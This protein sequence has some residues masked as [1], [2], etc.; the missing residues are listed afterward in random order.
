MI[1]T[2]TALA[3]HE[4][5]RIAI[6]GD[7]LL[8]RDLA[9]RSAGF[10]VDGLA[11]FGAG[12]ESA[13]LS[14]VAR[15]P[16]LREAMTWQNPAAVVNALDRVAEG[17]GVS[18]SKSRRREDVVASYWQ[19]YCAKN[20]TIGFY[21]PL[22][23]GRIAD[24]PAP[25]LHARSGDLIRERSVHLESWGVQTLA[26]SLDPELRVALGPRS[27]DDLRRL[28]EDHPDPG[29][30]ARGL[31]A[32][33]A[34]EAARDAL[35]RADGAQLPAALA[36]LDAEF[37]RLTGVAPT[38]H[39]GR[40]YGARTL[41]YVDCMRD[42]DVTLGPGFVDDIAPV[43]RAVFEAGRWYCGRI[44]AIGEAVIAAA[45]P[46][47]GRMPFAAIVPRIL[48]PL[49]ALPPAIDA[50]LAE[51]QRRVAALLDDPDETTLAAR[52]A[53]AF[54]DHQDAWRFA[55]YQSVDVQIAARDERAVRDGDYLAVIGD[56][57]PGSNP[58][59][60]GLFGNR[61]PSPDV[62]FELW[63]HEAGP[64]HLFLL[65]PWGPGI[66]A[67]ARGVPLLGDDAIHI[68]INPESCAPNGRR[69][70]RAEELW[71]EG[72]D[73]VDASGALRIA[74]TDVFAVPVFVTAVRTFELWPPAAHAS[75]LTVGRV[76][77]RRESWDVAPSEIPDS[78][79]DF[80]AWA[81]ALG[82]P[83]RVFVK[84]PIERKPFYL[85]L[86]SPA[87]RRIALRHMRAARGVGEPIRF[88]E[89]LPD[90]GQCWLADADGHRYASELRLV[91]VA[92]TPTRTTRPTV[93]REAC[94][95]NE[96]QR[97]VS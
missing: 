64:E 49:M 47:E 48:G 28:L 68:A 18:T 90:P 84:T 24:A 15:D 42:L 43:L 10:P 73:V 75:R 57:H 4:A 50:E 52:A 35:A 11:A 41:A 62:M 95:Y 79:G 12:D 1:A 8:W 60:Q 19:R 80:A 46:T 27:E 30:R 2:A 83:R 13:R 77:L 69:T 3:A 55:G 29:L 91:G 51:L 72:S 58:L 76:V 45:L 94:A 93:S 33:A 31:A 32:L 16:S 65:P 67:D 21:G 34:L 5:E 59:L 23:W 6:G 71:V 40:A 86:D 25:P 61:H 89:M 66:Q 44:E 81:R 20:D 70:W 85:D 82:M 56:V 36:A 53:V 9:V 96:H 17:A 74:L 88:T 37:V 22:A 54:A 92:A 14:E 7:W 97:R 26:A 78:A 39:H 63:R 38:R 87:L